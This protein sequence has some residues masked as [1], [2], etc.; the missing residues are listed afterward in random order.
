ML[1]NLPCVDRTTRT[2]SCTITRRHTEDSFSLPVTQCCLLNPSGANR[3]TLRYEQDNHDNKMSAQTI[4]GMSNCRTQTPR[5]QIP[6]LRIPHISQNLSLGKNSQN[7]SCAV[8][9][10]SG[11]H[12]LSKD[13]PKEKVFLMFSQQQ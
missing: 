9:F 5:L 11:T 1:K 8:I 7:N 13:M 12:N 4:Q 6:F 3:A 2:C 10:S